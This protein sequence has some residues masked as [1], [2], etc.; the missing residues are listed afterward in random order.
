[1]VVRIGVV[2]DVHF[3]PAAYFDGKLRK[4]THKA[5]ELL[6]AFVT[7]MN[8]E[9]APNLVVNLGDDI[10]DESVE[11]DRERY[12]EVVRRLSRARCEVEHV[13][14]NHD[15]VNLGP[16][17]LAAAWGRAAGPLYRSRDL[18]GLHLVFLHTHERKDES[19]FVDDEQLGWLEQDLV[20]TALPTIVFMHHSAADQ[21]LVGN[22]WFERAPHICLVR[23]RKRLRE[24]F[25]RSGRVLLVVNGHL[26]WNHLALHDGIP[27]VTLQSLVENLDDD[28]PGRAAAAH[29]VIH[30]EPRRLLVAVEGSDRCRYQFERA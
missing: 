28:A 14:G 15:V 3:G 18:A 26:H 24:L 22:R 30:V 9:V 25:A 2:S 20:A 27:Y 1:M 19:V 8:E 16:S 17:D 10:E 4:L 21:S 12:G 13:A 29:A 6:D 11:L 5:P 7:R 23:E